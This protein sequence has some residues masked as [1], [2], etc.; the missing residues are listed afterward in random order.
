MGRGEGGTFMFVFVPGSME[1]TLD[2]GSEV[3]TE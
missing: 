3:G 2:E 1:D